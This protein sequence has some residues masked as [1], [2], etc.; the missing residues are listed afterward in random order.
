MRVW[1]GCWYLLLKGRLSRPS[2]AN[3]FLYDVGH[4]SVVPEFV[5]SEGASAFWTGWISSDPLGDALL[6]ESMC[7]I[8]RKTWSAQHFAADATLELFH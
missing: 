8:Q 7:T 4:A 1:S 3:N 2:E 5:F 6:A